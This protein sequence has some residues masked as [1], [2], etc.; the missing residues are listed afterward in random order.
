MMLTLSDA[1]WWDRAAAAVRLLAAATVYS[2]ERVPV[3]GRPVL[4]RRNTARAQR[5]GLDHR[6][7]GWSYRTDDNSLRTARA[8][9]AWLSWHCIAS[10]ACGRNFVLSCSSFSVQS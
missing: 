2:G 4:K 8:V 6:E 3:T 9:L 10:H 1:Y 5:L 7:A